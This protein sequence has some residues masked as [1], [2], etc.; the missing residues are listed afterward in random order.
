MEEL[1]RIQEY[2][3]NSL[4]EK[5]YRHSIGTMKKAVELAKEY[6]INVGKAA[7]VG[8]SHDIAR[9]MQPEEML[10][11]V[12][13]NAILI[14]DIEKE[15]VVLLHSKIGADICKKRYGFTEDMVHAIGIHSIAEENMDMLS[16]IL[17]VADKI[18]E[19]RNYEE[20]EY[21]RELAKKDIDETILHILEKQIERDIARQR[22]M[23]PSSIRARNYLLLEKERKNGA[24]RDY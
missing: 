3:K 24:D 20:V 5:R 8:L 1:E 17:F 11:Y 19:T 16:K 2:L 14:E 18:E 23:I 4:S 13:K 22:Q 15:R 21:R 12:E 9:E 10:A 7:L 6:E